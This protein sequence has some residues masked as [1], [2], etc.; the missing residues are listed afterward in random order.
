VSKR[1]RDGYAN[2]RS[3][4]TPI[5]EIRIGPSGE[6]SYSLPSA[7]GNAVRPAE[8]MRSVLR[9]GRAA[10]W[11]AVKVV[12]VI[13]AVPLILIFAIASFGAMFFHG[14]FGW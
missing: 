3:G 5:R 12:F 4:L 11:L 13:I 6:W 7:G 1:R 2:P 14:G 10:V 8:L 9:I